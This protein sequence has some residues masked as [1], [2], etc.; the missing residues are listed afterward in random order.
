MHLAERKA[1]TFK[2]FEYP[3]CAR[4]PTVCQAPWA[5]YVS[6][7]PCSVPPPGLMYRH[8]HCGQTE[9]LYSI[10]VPSQGLTAQTCP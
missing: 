8:S 9:A 2:F 3:L 6:S 10:K 5:T 7:V 4:I 1:V